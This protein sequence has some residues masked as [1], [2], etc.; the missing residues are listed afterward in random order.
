MEYI[1]P[2][3]QRG[4]LAK[5]RPTAWAAGLDRRCAPLLNWPL[6]NGRLNFRHEEDGFTQGRNDFA[7]VFQIVIGQSPDPRVLKP[8]FANLIS[9]DV[10]ASAFGEETFS[11]HCAP[12]KAPTAS[13]GL[14]GS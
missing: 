12:V 13:T 10:G 8:L 5:P 3:P 11:P 1:P 4:D 2:E 7:V 6:G 14:S 9:A